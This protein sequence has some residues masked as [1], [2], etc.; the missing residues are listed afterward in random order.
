MN[1]PGFD[2]GIRGFDSH[3]GCH[4]MEGANEYLSLI[5]FATAIQTLTAPSVQTIEWGV[6]DDYHRIS[7]YRQKHIVSKE[8]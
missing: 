2:P 5:T 7:R 4:C 6:I 3:L 1:A 8:L